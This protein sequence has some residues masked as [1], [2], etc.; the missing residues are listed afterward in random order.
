MYVVPCTHNQIQGLITFQTDIWMPFAIILYICI[1]FALLGNLICIQRPR[2]DSCRL[3]LY[4]STINNKTDANTCYIACTW[5]CY[6]RACTWLCA[7]ICY[8]LT[9][10]TPHHWLVDWHQTLVQQYDT[11]AAGLHNVGGESKWLCGNWDGQLRWIGNTHGSAI[12]L[13]IGEST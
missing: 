1:Y 6:V 2:V 12:E 8:E 4:P 9:G 10:R 5:L 3:T 7:C 13:E 11:D